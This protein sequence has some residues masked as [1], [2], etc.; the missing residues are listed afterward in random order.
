MFFAEK[1]FF[2]FDQADR[3]TEIQVIF[4]V[5]TRIANKVPDHKI[6]ARLYEQQGILNTAWKNY[7]CA[8]KAFIKMK[9]V[10]ED[11]RDYNN[12]MRAYVYIGQTF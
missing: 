2:D 11:A 10:A 4:N 3:R 8:V 12:I 1:N 5:A 9:D 7:P 6:S